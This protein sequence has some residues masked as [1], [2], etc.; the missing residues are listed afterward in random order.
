M[1]RRAILFVFF[2]VVGLALSIIPCRAVEGD[3]P[4]RRPNVVLIMA[5]DMGY[6][7]LGCN[8][9]ADYKT[10]NL[11][12]LA[13]NGIRFTHCYSQPLCTPSRVKIMT[14]RYN[15]R[16]YQE[17]GY[18]DQQETTF[19]HLLQAAGYQTC[20]AGKWQLNGLTYKMPGYNDP[21]RAVRSGFHEYCLWQLTQPRKNGERFADALIEENGQPPRK[22]I[23]DYGPQVF[24]DFVCDFIQRNRD[25]PFFVYYP[26]VLTHDPFVPTPDSPEWQS[27][28]RMQRDTRFFADM[29]AYT[30]RIV[31]QIDATLEML[32][33]RENTILLFTGDNGTHPSITTRLND[34]TRIQGGKGSTLEAGTHVPLIASWPGTAPRGRTNNDLIDFSD[35]FATLA[36]VAGDPMAAEQTD[37]RSFCPQLKGERGTPREFAFCHYSPRWG[38]WRETTRFA[39][40]KNYKLYLDGRIYNVSSDLLEERQLKPGDLIEET[41]R[42]RLE[43]VLKSMPPVEDRPPIARKEW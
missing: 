21:Q 17:F 1:I 11:N 5:D 22:R 2:A 12:R 15:F 30:D 28:N 20:I 3:R 43:A 42:R 7:C 31:G 6:E 38:K 29:V 32:G 34:G 25:R 13:A 41:I 14:G 27:G 8:G 26:M 4:R 16:N 9:A 10:P 23:G 24:A 39:R 33:I 35:F 40:T 37:G 36:D 18:L 19:G